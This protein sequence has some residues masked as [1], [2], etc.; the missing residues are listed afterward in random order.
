MVVSSSGELSTRIL[1]LV[2]AT[3]VQHAPGMRVSLLASAVATTCD[4]S[5]LA[6][7]SSQGPRLCLGRLV[8]RRSTTRAA[9]TKR[10]SSRRKQNVA[11]EGLLDFADG[12]QA[13]KLPRSV[14]SSPCPYSGI[15]CIVAVPGTGGGIGATVGAAV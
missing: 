2:S 6:A 4:A 3:V 5:A 14:A 9:R 12:P 13:T 8:G 11:A 15:T 10:T 1:M 7:A